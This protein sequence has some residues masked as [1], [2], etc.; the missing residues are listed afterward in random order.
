M[1]CVSLVRSEK[2]YRRKLILISKE[3]GSWA[4]EFFKFELGIFL[5][6]KLV[7]EP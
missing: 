4:A 7:F 6:F 5:F 1:L 3:S 2:S